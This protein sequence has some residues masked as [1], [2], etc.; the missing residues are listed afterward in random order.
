MIMTGKRGYAGRTGPNSRKTIIKTSLIDLFESDYFNEWR[1]SA[2]IAD[3][4]TKS[5]SKHWGGVSS[6]V[7]G[8][9]MV[10]HLKTYNIIR[11]YKFGASGAVRYISQEGFDAL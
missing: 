11:K 6:H 2:E 4:V 9:I 10:R 8:S 3:E 7:I 5:L 1:T